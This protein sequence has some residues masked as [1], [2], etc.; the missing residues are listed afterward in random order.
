MAKETTQQSNR[1]L[2]LLVRIKDGIAATGQVPL[3]LRGRDGS[4]RRPSS[5]ALDLIWNACWSSGQGNQ[6]QLEEW[7][8][9][10]GTCE[11]RKNELRSLLLPQKGG[12][13]DAE[14]RPNEPEARPWRRIL[15]EAWDDGQAPWKKAPRHPIIANWQNA[16][17]VIPTVFGNDPCRIVTG[18]PPF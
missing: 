2:A 11:Y 15:R 6:Q 7:I 10:L 4:C 9:N 17:P 3:F 5:L 12:F 16:F 18:K 13:K 1:K 8:R 14:L